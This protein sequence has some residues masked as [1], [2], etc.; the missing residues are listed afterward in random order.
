M[1][2]DRRRPSRGAPNTHLSQPWSQQ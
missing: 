2:R 1:K